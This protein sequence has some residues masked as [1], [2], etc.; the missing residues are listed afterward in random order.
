MIQIWRWTNVR[1]SRYVPKVSAVLGLF[2]AFYL[3]FV[4]RLDPDFGWALEAGRFF[5]MHGVPAHDVFSYT[6]PNFAWIDHEW[7]ADVLLALVMGFGGFAA[8]AAFFA[9]VWTAA[10]A[11]AAPRLSWPVLAMSFAAVSADVVARTNAWTA[12]LLAGLLMAIRDQ[13]LERYRWWLL[14]YFVL[15]ANLHGG[16]VLGLVVVA[17]EATRRRRLWFP[18]LGAVIATFINPY[19]PRLYVEIWRTLSD[20]SLHRY[21][22]EWHPLSLGMFSGFYVVACLAF[23]AISGWQRERFLLPGL[24]LISSIGAER[25]FMLFVVASANLIDN[26]FLRF[27]QFFGLRGSWK[28]FVFTALGVCMVAVPVY[29]I[30]RQPMNAT[31]IHGVADLRVH[32]CVG[33][34]FNEYDF[35]GYLI[36]Q[37]PGT[38]V[39]IDGRMPSWRQGQV[40]YLNNWVQDIAVARDAD[41][42]FRKYGIACALL[43]PRHGRLIH[44]L[45]SEGWKATAADAIGVLLRKPS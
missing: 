9:A 38:R 45:E 32:P 1:Y 43:E 22:G 26:G 37:L 21:I 41:A 12:L 33:N 34:I 2:L 39:Y 3:V 35:G 14:P 19:G 4:I 23:V 31:P 42:D 36:W 6:A 17:L 8:V 29:K 30:W 27:E 40:S 20:G 28:R 7:L 18:W 13:Q 15:W 25:Q 11:I 24:L 44:Q 5:L 10:L 16:F